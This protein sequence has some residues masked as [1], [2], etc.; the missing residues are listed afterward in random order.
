[1][2]HEDSSAQLQKFL[3]ENQYTKKGILRYEKIFGSG[4]VSTGGIETTEVSC[5]EMEYCAP[6]PDNSYY[7]VCPSMDVTTSM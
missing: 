2:A 4:F 3:D 1:M 7:G 6:R 5:V